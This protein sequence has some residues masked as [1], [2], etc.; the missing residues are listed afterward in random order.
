[1]SSDVF[2]VKRA[3]RLETEIMVPG[4]KSISHRAVMLAALSNGV[5]KITNFLEGEDCL[6]TI[7]AFQQLGV[8][9]ERPDPGLVVVYG[10]HGKLIAPEGDID[11]GNS[12]TTLRLLAGILAAQPFT[13]RLIGDASLSKRPMRRI[14]EPLTQMGATITALGANDSPPLIVHGGPLHG[15]TYRTPV[16]SAQVKSAILLAGL[17]APGVTTVIEPAPSRDHTERM[18]EY[19]LVNL[20]RED[21]R[22]DRNRKAHECRVSMLGQQKIESRDFAVPG[23]I[24]SAAFWLVAAACQPGSRLLVKNVGLNPTRTGILDVLVRMGAR[25]REVVESVEEGEPA[26]IIDIKGGQLTGTVIEGN[27]VPNV[28]DEIPILA[29]AGALAEGRTIIRDA[30]E[31]RVKET[32]RIAAIAANLRAMGVEVH[33]AEDGMTI[34]G[35]GK[36]TGATLNSFGDHRIAMAFGIAG[37]FAS[38]TTLIENAECVRTSY[39]QFEST[40]THLQRGDRTLRHPTPVISS[41]VGK[42]RSFRSFLK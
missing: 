6:S 4:D 15:I 11:C 36:L 22:P 25:I 40:L 23:D 33:E 29:V 41:L 19:F 31:L 26:G 24:S 16:A 37:L 35:G 27:E 30:R 21:G 3:P 42:R 20:R 18:L 8:T 38:G 28:I 1:M 5:C 17:S 39:P 32:D 9:I 34:Y 7:R 10:S 13:S 2:R 12:G 14:I